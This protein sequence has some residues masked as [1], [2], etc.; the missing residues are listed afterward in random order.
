[1]PLTHIRIEN[2]KS[3][4][5]C[6]LD[7]NNINALIGANGT[8]KTNILDAISYFYS[9]LT[10]QHVDNAVF[11]LNNKFSNQVRIT[12]TFDLTDFVKISKT[13][14]DDLSLLFDDE[15]ENDRY[16][17]YYRA[18]ISLASTQ[19]NNKFS[20]KMVQTKGKG[21]EWSEKYENR[22]IIKSLFPCFYVNTRDLDINEWSQVWSVLGELGKV[23]NEQ[24]NTIQDNIRNLVDRDSEISKKIKGIQGIFDSSE[25][26]IRPATS[27]EFA[28]TLSKLYF[29]GQTIY[30]KGRKLKYFSTG[31]NSVKYIELLLK[32]INEIA[33]NKL[34]EP[35]VMFDEPETSLHPNYVDELAE[36]YLNLDNR[37]RIIISTHSSRLI[38]NIMTVSENLNLHRVSISEKHSI[39]KKMKKYTQYSPESKY[40]VL[41]DHINSYFSRAILFVE[42][43]TEL[44]LFANP[45]LQILFPQLKKIDVY[46]AM[47]EKPI[48]NIML[49]AQN[50]AEIPYICLIDADKAINF[51]DSSY[52]V[53]LR[54]EFLGSEREKYLFRNKKDREIYLPHQRKKIEKMAQK[55][56]IHCFKPFYSCN[57]QYFAQFID[58]VKTYLSRYNI[59]MFATDIEAALINNQSYPYAIDYLKKHNEKGDFDAFDTYISGMM[60]TDKINILRIVFAGHSDLFKSYKSIKKNIPSDDALILDRVMGNKKADGWVS[61]YI[62]NF[63]CSVLPEGYEKSPRGMMKYF[64]DEENGKKKVL[65]EFK[66]YF[67]ELH[68][69]FV[70]L[71][72]IMK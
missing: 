48:L 7:L 58:S 22:F 65:S 16:K 43:E 37:L 70:K 55:L 52:A 25:V 35:I 5:R 45:Y 28:T 36:S 67:S 66:Y 41:D 54:S 11:D 33:K 20:L 57:D 27:K 26:S 29:D 6:D 38:K 64:E 32:A 44:E 19:K 21:I 40:R 3:I 60:N 69:L 14:T 15:A 62:D 46:K 17:N 9:N 61:D 24:R 31:T 8:G 42:G 13:H 12:L 47:T 4:K 72:G 10:E 30:Q 49:P 68:S 51:N 23:S 2:Y 59:F 34:K 1:M 71:Y 53:S 56:H 39:V 18:I 50:K 63:F